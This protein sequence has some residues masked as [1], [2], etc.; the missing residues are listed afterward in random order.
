M[1]ETLMKYVEELP[2][3][4]QIAIVILLVI[5]VL[6]VPSLLSI[7][8]FATSVKQKLC[9]MVQYC[10][11]QKEKKRER[12]LADQEFRENVSNIMT[13]IPDIYKKINGVIND[14]NA[15][16][17]SSKQNSEQN[18]KLESTLSKMATELKELSQRSK[19]NDDELSTHSKTNRDNI[20]YL[21]ERVDN[22][23]T[24][25]EKIDVKVK[26]LVDGD[27]DDFRTFLIQVYNQCIT[28]DHV[29]SKREISVLKNKYQ[30]YR[31]EGGNGWAKKLMTE[32]A[33][34]IGDSDLL[35]ICK[36]DEK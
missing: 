35:E 36:N 28:G 15:V 11:K 24:T 34:E 25:V 30:R 12:K 1:E 29:L 33:E 27:I 31:A 17:S 23:A 21:I 2:P 3:H 8:D 22:L 5:G 9:K 13:S 14:M 20:K 6:I 4:I 16:V 18:E 26:L 10:K 32:M 19:S 7:G